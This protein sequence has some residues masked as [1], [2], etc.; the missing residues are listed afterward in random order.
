MEIFVRRAEAKDAKEIGRILYEVHAVHHALRP[1]LFLE[2]KRKYDEAGVKQ[3]I[4]STP[5][6]VAEDESKVLGYAVCF[7]EET[8]EGGSMR[9]KKTLYL[10]DLCVDESARKRGVGH[11][12]FEA[13][14]ALARELGCYDL[15][16]NVWEGNT[17]ARAFYDA[18]GMKPLKTY[19]EKI[20]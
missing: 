6:L 8:K 17:A 3:L 13:V 14:E 9:A 18:V 12:L 5:V 4:S 10:D 2:G 15:T 7:L 20:L 1:D 11:K 19:L 16:L